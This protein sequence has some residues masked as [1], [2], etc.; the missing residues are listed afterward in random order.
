MN[1]SQG[2]RQVKLVSH[3]PTLL[4]DGEWPNVARH[5][6]PFITNLFTPFI[7]ENLNY[8]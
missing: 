8:T 7:G 2:W 3:D 6:F 5:Y 1:S 4:E